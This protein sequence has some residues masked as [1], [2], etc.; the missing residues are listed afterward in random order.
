MLTSLNLRFNQLGDEGAEAIGDALKVNGVL[1]HLNLVHN[2]IGVEGA[3]A[4]REIAN[5]LL[6]DD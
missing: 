1:T 4:L 5:G 3:K 6:F 2:E